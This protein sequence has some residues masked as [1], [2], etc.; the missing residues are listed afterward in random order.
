MFYP[1]YE[2]MKERKR[3]NAEAYPRGYLQHCINDL[4]R[5]LLIYHARKRSWYAAGDITI[6]VWKIIFLSFFRIIFSP[7]TRFWLSFSKRAFRNFNFSRWPG[8][9]YFWANIWNIFNNT[10]LLFLYI[11]IC[12]EY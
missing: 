8:F 3:E 6:R 12:L 7:F 5:R 11:Y 1:L 2:D 4:T 9:S 10:V